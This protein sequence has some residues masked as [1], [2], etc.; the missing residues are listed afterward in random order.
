M[1]CRN[2]F[3]SDERPTIETLDFTIRIGSTA[4]SINLYLFLFGIFYCTWE[5]IVNSPTGEGK[6]GRWMVGWMDK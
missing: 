3:V 6:D 5:E 1:Y 2:M 4:F